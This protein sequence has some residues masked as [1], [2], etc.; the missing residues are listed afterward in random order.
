METKINWKRVWGKFDI[1]FD[2]HKDKPQCK[3]CGHT[4]LMELEWEEQQKKIQQ[5]V[6]AQVRKLGKENLEFVEQICWF[7]V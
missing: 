4:E 5:L 7:Y 1:W 2:K 6:A 3:T